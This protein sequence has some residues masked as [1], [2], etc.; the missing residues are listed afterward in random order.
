MKTFWK[1][2]LTFA[3]L[4]VFVLVIA[5]VVGAL[6]SGFNLPSMGGGDVKVVPVH[7]QITLGGCP[8][9]LL[10]I[11]QCAQVEV[12]K[13]ELRKADKDPQVKAIVLDVYSGGGN[14]VASRELMRAVRDTK[15]PVVSWIGEVGASGAYYV[16]SASDRIVADEN[17]IT[18]SIGVIMFIQHYYELFDEIGINVTVLTAGETK[19]IGSPYRP[20]TDE[21]RQ[22]L[23]DMINKVYYTFMRDVAE[24]R[25][26]DMEYV[27]NISEG[28]IY[29]GSEAAEIGLVD[30]VGGFD[31]AVDVAAELGGI[32]GEP[33]V[34][35]PERR[36]RWTDLL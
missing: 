1:V 3:V 5:F 2:A 25:G 18:G 29:L 8:S 27:R 30:E 21:E 32:T 24:N 15:K 9:G 36:L 19:D 26:L 35:M 14:I 22:E 17:S 11:Q 31:H 16:A 33:G 13:D 23:Q 12:I 6:M 4:A 34:R 20:M 7:G 10:T 28:N